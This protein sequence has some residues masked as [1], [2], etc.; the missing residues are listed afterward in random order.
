[1]SRYLV[2]GAAGF[3]GHWL[4]RRLLQG[5]SLVVGVDNLN[6]AYDPRLKR[7]RLERLAESSR[8]R[9]H[10]TDVTDGGALDKLIEWTVVQIQ[11]VEGYFFFLP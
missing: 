11:V 5:G 8:F 3:I 9:F 10:A 4:V 6:A 7:W 2:T 1:M